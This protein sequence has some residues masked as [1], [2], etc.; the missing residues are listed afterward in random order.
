MTR[1]AAIRAIMS[2]P[3]VGAFTQSGPFICVG[4]A[5]AVEWVKNTHFVG[6]S[7]IDID[8]DGTVWIGADNTKTEIT[9]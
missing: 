8:A 6:K 7:F 3:D 4:R 2:A 9:E 5:K 1:D